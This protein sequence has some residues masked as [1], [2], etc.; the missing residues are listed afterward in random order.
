MKG[1]E[2]QITWATEIRNNI[3]NTFKA[4]MAEIPADEKGQAV[5]DKINGMIARLEA[6]ENAGDIINLFKGVH[7]G[8]NL[9][10]SVA[11]VMTI[12]KITSPSTPGE[13]AILGR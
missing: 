2:K 3:I 8:D 12:Y 13:R 10:N 4:S 6:A 5:R 11:D 9:R 1:S 7:F